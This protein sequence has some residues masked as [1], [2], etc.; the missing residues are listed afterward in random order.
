MAPISLQIPQASAQDLANEN[1][2]N[3]ARETPG[4]AKTVENCRSTVFV[5][6][7]DSPAG[8][9]VNLLAKVNE[10]RRHAVLRAGRDVRTADHLPRALCVSPDRPLRVKNFTHTSQQDRRPEGLLKEFN[11]IASQAMGA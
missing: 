10:G 4:K 7:N 1:V 2:R 6:P 8:R 3:G 11:T 5:P 9:P